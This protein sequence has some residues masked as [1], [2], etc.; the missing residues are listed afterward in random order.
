M[1]DR[2][3]QCRITWGQHDSNPLRLLKFSHFD[4]IS[5]INEILRSAFLT[6]KQVSHRVWLLFWTRMLRM[7]PKSFP[8]L[9]A[10]VSPIEEKKACLPLGPSDLRVGYS[11]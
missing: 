10:S 4:A 8:G 1:T 7:T 6:S 5:A 9:C 11:R 3:R 2:R